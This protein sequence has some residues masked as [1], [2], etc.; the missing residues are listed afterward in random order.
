M[1]YK[2]AIY[3][4][5]TPQYVEDPQSPKEVD[6]GSLSLPTGLETNNTVRMYLKEI[7]HI[8]LLS[9]EEEVDLGHRVQ[10]GDEK[11]K[12][13]L[14]GANL[15]LV[16][17]VAK[18]YTGKGLQML[19]LLQ[20]GN[21]GLIRA[22]EKYD[23]HRGLKFS[24]YAVWWIRQSITRAIA[25]QSQMIRK[26][27]HMVDRIKQVIYEQR[28]LEQTLGRNPTPEEISTKT[29]LSS[30]QIRYA[31][32]VAQQPISLEEPMGEEDLTLGDM[33]PNSKTVSPFA[34]IAYNSLKGHIEDALDI[35]TGQERQVLQL[36]YGLN[37]NRP[38]TFDE[39]A[40]VIDVKRDRVRTIESRALRSLRRSKK[41]KG[42]RDF[43]DL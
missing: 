43:L 31:L 22:A 35:L 20:E 19:D 33:V 8:D 27:V 5:D 42:L 38:Y 25:N 21:T 32:R 10:K 23:P 26:P 17:N 12:G 34:Q 36:R 29:D 9:V 18:G 30:D 6:Q 13:K 3:E 14:I 41:F 37:H 28:Q 2:E 1:T 24:T 4:K 39:I 40:H 7:G 16:V 15:R 11:A